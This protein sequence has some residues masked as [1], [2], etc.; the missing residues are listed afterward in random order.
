MKLVYILSYWSFCVSSSS[1]AQMKLK[2]VEL[3]KYFAL[4]S[5]LSNRMRLLIH[6]DLYVHFVKRLNKFLLL[7][8]DFFSRILQ[9]FPK[10]IIAY[11]QMTKI[12]NELRTYAWVYTEHRSGCHVQ[13]EEIFAAFRVYVL[14]YLI[15]VNLLNGV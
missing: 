8:T 9:L 7:R 15:N 12:A 5:S 1:T 10:N 13:A 2:K 11:E 3:C 14:T 4:L 6:S